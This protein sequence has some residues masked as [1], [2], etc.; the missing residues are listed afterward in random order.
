MQASINVMLLAAIIGQLSMS[1]PYTSQPNTPVL[2]RLYM[3]SEMPDKS[4]VFNECNAWGTNA[5]V[6][7]NAAL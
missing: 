5:T 6:V 3:G 7:S 1:N 4:R 2:N